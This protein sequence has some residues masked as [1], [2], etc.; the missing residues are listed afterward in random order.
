MLKVTG[1]T[2]ESYTFTSLEAGINYEFEVF[3][4][5][6]AGEGFP[7]SIFKQICDYPEPPSSL[8]DSERGYDSVTLA[9]VAPFEVSG[10]GVTFSILLDGTVF[11]NNLSGTSYTVDGLTIGSTYSFVVFS[12]N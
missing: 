1:V 12:Q 8:T 2:T 3:A 4:N 9:W 11:A 10:C 7:D 6:L 5:N